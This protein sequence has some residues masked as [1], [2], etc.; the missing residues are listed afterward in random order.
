MSISFNCPAPLRFAAA[1]RGTMTALALLAVAGCAGMNT[2]SPENEARATQFSEQAGKAKQAGKIREAAMLYEQAADLQPGN[3]ALR[4]EEGNALLAVGDAK[5]ARTAFE[6]ILKQ[7]PQ[8]ADALA[9]VA[10]AD[11]QLG[12][13]GDAKQNFEQS[14]AVAPNPGTYA[15]YGSV[16]DI[17][18]DHVKAQATYRQGLALSP[19]YLGLR[20]NIAL[21]LAMQEDYGRAIDILKSVIAKP[22]ATPNHR[23]NLAMVYALAG[24]EK[25]ARRTLT[26]DL[27]PDQIDRN[28]LI[29]NKM[30]AK[31]GAASLR[32]AL[33]GNGK[34]DAGE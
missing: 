32:D 11:M 21:S 20:N 27:R 17:E 25:A 18:G 34:G 1:L 33:A 3:A 4:L 5:A 31:G 8:N 14:L 7:D 12:R 13:Y 26:Q 19:D 30:R 22:E 24:Q 23:A 10:R 15:G 6:K 28:I 2:A 16:F 29:Y 9:G